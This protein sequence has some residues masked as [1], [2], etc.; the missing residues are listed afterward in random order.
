ME[1][2]RQGWIEVANPF[3]PHTISKVSLLPE[4]V[5]AIVFWTRNAKPLIPH[6]DELDSLGYKYL[7]LYT[8]TGYPRILEPGC[9]DIDD[10][11]LTMRMLSDIIGPDRIIWRYDPIFISSLTPVDYH[12]YNF[13][14]ITNKLNGY[15]KRVIISLFDPYKSALRRIVKRIP[16][17]KIVDDPEQDE[18]LTELISG[19]LEVCKDCNMEIKSC[20]ED[21]MRFGVGAGACIDGELLQ[22][23]FNIE[24]KTKKDP[25][26]RINCRCI[27]SKD[28]GIYN[29]CKHGC[30]YCYA[31]K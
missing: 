20:C 17:I 11:V 28:I 2:V 4:D 14:D 6:L 1:S 13:Q 21:L 26:Q 27:Q 18:L 10:A 8:L 31:L 12:L 19:M 9:P 30:I 25:G 29:T 3:N 23:L 16:D 5:D 15:C 24:I 7:F 22:Q